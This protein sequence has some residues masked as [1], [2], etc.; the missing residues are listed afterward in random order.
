M[1]A[2]EPNTKGNGAG[3]NRERARKELRAERTEVVEAAE[4]SFYIGTHAHEHQIQNGSGVT[5]SGCIHFLMQFRCTY[6]YKRTYIYLVL[7]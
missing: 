1:L 7:F 4:V 5:V 2:G 6:V 3:R